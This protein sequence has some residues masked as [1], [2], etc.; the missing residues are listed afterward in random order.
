M[1]ACLRSA[2]FMYPDLSGSIVVEL[3]RHHDTDA[4]CGNKEFLVTKRLTR[5]PGVV[6]RKAFGTYP[7]AVRYWD[8][9]VA[10][11]TDLGLV[12]RDSRIVGFHEEG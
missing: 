11:V 2:Q 6:M 8:E 7:E 9:E 5:L 10:K 4:R 12:R 3:R 1:L